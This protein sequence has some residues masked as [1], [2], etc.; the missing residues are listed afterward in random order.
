MCIY[1]NKICMH[2]M[3]CKLIVVVAQGVTKLV[4]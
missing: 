4:T 2:G 1:L 3:L